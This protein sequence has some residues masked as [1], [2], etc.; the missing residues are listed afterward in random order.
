[1]K[2][3]AS[4]AMQPLVNGCSE[5]RRSDEHVTD[6]VLVIY[7]ILPVSPR[8]DWGDCPDISVKPEYNSS[9]LFAPA[10][11]IARHALGQ[12]GRPD[13]HIHTLLASKIR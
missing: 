9:D 4:R 10:N 13:G 6:L 5:R 11:Q 3:S 12:T 8:T 2:P 7:P 1:M